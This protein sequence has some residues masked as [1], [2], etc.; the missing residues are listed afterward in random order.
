MRLIHTLLFLFRE[1]RIEEDISLA[2]ACLKS[3]EK[4]TYKT[5]IVYNQGF[6]T[7]EQVK[8]FLKYFDLNCIVIGD[9]VN[10]GTV[11][12]RQACF[13]YIWANYADTDYISEIHLDMIFPP[14]WEDALVEYLD[15]NDEPM[16]SSGIIDAQKNLNFLDQTAQYIPTDLNEFDEF[17]ENLR[18]DKIVH[19][20]TNPCVHVSKIL[21][22]AGGYDKNFLKG[23]QCHEDDSMLL[24]YYYYYGTKENWHPKVNYN[25][26]VYH[27]IAGQRMVL[28]DFGANVNL[29]YNGLILQY[30]VMGLKHLSELHKSAWHKNFF[31]AEYNRLIG[32]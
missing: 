23:K 22:I 21:K 12:G 20:F 18:I 4:A 3:L 31:G 25:T 15:K 14:H 16:I 27:A 11:V 30:G 13:E 17:L 5:V 7:D 19:G 29:N 8:D 28:E 2:T 26:V 9:G 1:G 24:G 32:K 6:L 10:V